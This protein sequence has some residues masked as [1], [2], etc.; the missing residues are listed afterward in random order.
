MYNVYTTFVDG[1]RYNVHFRFEAAE[2]EWYNIDSSNKHIKVED[3]DSDK[4]VAVLMNDDAVEGYREGLERGTAWSSTKQPWDPLQE[5]KEFV[6]TES[7]FYDEY[8]TKHAQVESDAINPSHYKDIVPGYQYAE[9]MKYMLANQTGVEAHLLGQVY[10]YLMRNG[11]KDE[12]VQELN[13]AEWY[14]KALIKHKT[15]GKVI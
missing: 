3:A 10:K 2:N 4:L 5:H 14:L 1:K 13:K 7:D 8:A 9:M 6:K 12:E 11:K 15:E